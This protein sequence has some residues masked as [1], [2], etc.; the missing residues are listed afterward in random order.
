M[1]F[2]WEIDYF[3]NFQWNFLLEQVN[4]SYQVAHELLITS[5]DCFDKK[6]LKSNIF[7]EAPVWVFFF[8]KKNND[9]DIQNID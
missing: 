5:R 2:F 8:F 6:Y 3:N 4:L 9:G 1:G 7:C